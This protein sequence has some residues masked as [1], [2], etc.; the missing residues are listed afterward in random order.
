MG[1]CFSLRIG[2]SWVGAA[3]DEAEHESITGFPSRTPELRTRKRRCPYRP[4]PLISQSW[5]P[6]LA[7]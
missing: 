5:E 4:A 1:L 6:E 3:V 7:T 2:Q